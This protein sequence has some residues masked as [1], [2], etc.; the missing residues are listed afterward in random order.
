MKIYVHFLGQT[1]V[2]AMRVLVIDEEVPFPLNSGKRLRTFN[3]LK[4]LASRHEITFVCRYHDG[5][6]EF[7]PQQLEA[8]G[9]RTVVVPHPVLKKA[10][11]RF[12]F[13]LLANVLSRYPYVATS[14]HSAQLI[15][16]IKSLVE[17]DGFDLIHCE[18]TPYA[19]NVKPFLPAPSVVVAHNVES[20]IWR[21]NFEIEKNPLKKAYIYLQYKK[22]EQ[23]E[24]E[25][26][27]LFTRVVAVSD[28]DKALIDQ[29]APEDQ[30][31][32]VPNGVDID[33]FRSSGL[34]QKPH[35][36]VFTG[37]LDW[38]PNVDCM[39]Y[40][41]D[42]IWPL[43]LQTFP[44]ASFTIVGR[45]PTR[46]LQDRMKNEH[47]VKL[48]GTVDDVRPYIEK[49]S[50]Y[51]VP[52]RIGG[53]SRLKILEALSMRKAVVSTSIG[54]E[55]LTVIPDRELLIADE[56]EDFAKAIAGLFQDPALCDRLGSSGHKLVEK[57]YQWK[58]LANKLEEVWL[59]ALDMGKT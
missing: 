34:S 38:R 18:W 13:T 27:S 23:F 17:K 36:V 10:G 7:D 3:L 42:E 6:D 5:V 51:I 57:H 47:S 30:S 31:T 28:Q 48:T 43:V 19:I 16:V 9:I 53:G 33:Y 29:W 45:R 54:A 8:A 26:F 12:Y 52:L 58:A 41:L 21:R 46:Q 32:V 11:L 56:P 50:V 40:F 39:L 1:T 22:M 4:H 25:A 2:I 14:H 15:D 20:M 24:R 44:N 35:S 59:Q 55:G 49:A 37:S